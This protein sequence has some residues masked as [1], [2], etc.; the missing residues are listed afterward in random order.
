MALTLALVA[1]SAAPARAQPLLHGDVAYLTFQRLMDLV[2]AAVYHTEG[3]AAVMWNGRRLTIDPATLRTHLDSRPSSLDGR[4]LLFE[5]E[6]W[7]PLRALELFGAEV[8]YEQETREAV[9][10]WFEGE[11][12]V[13]LNGARQL[14]EPRA[15]ADAR[16]VFDTLRRLSDPVR[17]SAFLATARQTGINAVVLD[18]KDDS[19][20]LAYPS[21]HPLARDAGAIRPAAS[22][23]AALVAT[24]RAS[25]LYVIA[26]VVAFKDTV[27]ARRRPDLAIRAAGTDRPLRS[28]LGE[29]WIDPTLPEVTD[30][31]LQVAREIAALGVDEIQFDYIRFPDSRSSPD[32]PLPAR[33]ELRRSDVIA[34]FLARANRALHVPISVDLFGIAVWS[35]QE[36]IGQSLELILPHIQAI[37]PM[38]YPS[39]FDPAFRSRSGARRAYDIVREGVERSAAASG[40]RVIVRPWLQ[41]FAAS[42]FAYGPEFLRQQLDGARDGGAGGFLLW[43]SRFD[44]ANEYQ[45]LRTWRPATLAGR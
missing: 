27:L 44:Y 26:R 21:A 38:L 35:E 20:Y 28:A 23:V 17:L 31:V 36:V 1:G 32:V 43:N 39:Y 15:K 6:L 37:S 2:G 16:A 11:A 7:L 42:P 18:F 41:A 34:G 25:G 9:L 5:D 12:R 3:V 45:V 4:V 29:M 19:G 33:P 30:Y 24:L 22:D 8:A 40:G 14:H 10:V 13:P